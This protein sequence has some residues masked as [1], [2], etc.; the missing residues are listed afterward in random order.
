LSTYIDGLRP[1]LRDRETVALYDTIRPHSALGLP[2]A[3]G[4]H[5]A[6]ALSSAGKE[7]VPS[8]S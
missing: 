1:R 4:V 2:D 5:H 3:T 8:I 6:M 7:V